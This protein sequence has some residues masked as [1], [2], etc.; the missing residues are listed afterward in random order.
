MPLEARGRPLHTRT[1]EITLRGE[2]P[3]KAHGRIL[4]I[5]HST[6]APMTDRL[7]LAGVIHDM[8]VDLEVDAASLAI[9][10]LAIEQPT[11]AFEASEATG[12]ESCRDPADNL[13]ALV[14]Q[15]IDRGLMRR[16]SEVHGGPRGCTHL[17]TLISAM[18]AT[19]RQNARLGWPESRRGAEEL[20]HRRTIVL[21]YLLAEGETLT[22]AAQLS[23]FSSRPEAEVRHRFDRLRRQHEVAAA[24]EVA[25]ADRCVRGVSLR[26][27]LRPEDDLALQPWVDRSAE[28]EELVG[29]PILGGAGKR[30]HQRFGAEEKDAPLL[31]VLLQIPVGFIQSLPPLAEPAFLHRLSSKER[32]GEDGEAPDRQRTNMGN[33]CY[34]WRDESP[35]LKR[36][37]A[38]S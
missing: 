27:R 35:W 6:Y 16:L 20:V 14:G 28:L 2:D 32:P 31:D 4:D 24:V 25:I 18:S 17:F 5:R 37:L 34:M 1:L 21:D 38:G 3:L 8:T 11:I 33:A 30:I 15:T 36:D 12:G 9:R 23:D 10:S 7:Q 29:Q 19:I 13:Q 26:E 22:V